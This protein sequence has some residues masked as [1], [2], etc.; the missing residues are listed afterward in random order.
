MF[1]GSQQWHG[2]SSQRK[3][4]NQILFAVLPLKYVMLVSGILL[5]DILEANYLQLSYY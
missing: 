2:F 4:V 3:D 1:Q 5:G